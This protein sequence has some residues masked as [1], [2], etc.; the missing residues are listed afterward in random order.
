L[1]AEIHLLHHASSTLGV[2]HV[3]LSRFKNCNYLQQ[4]PSS[5]GTK[6]RIAPTIFAV[7]RIS[8]KA[9]VQRAR[10]KCSHALYNAARGH[11]EKS[12]TRKV[13]RAGRKETPTHCITNLRQAVTKVAHTFLC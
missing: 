13:W 4:K 8:I 12:E 6:R 1:R 2:H 9:P 3:G 7:G 5:L 11:T 10:G